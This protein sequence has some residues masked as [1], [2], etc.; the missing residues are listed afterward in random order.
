MLPS[1]LAR[2]IQQG[3]KHFLITGFESADGCDHV[4]MQR[5]VDNE[6]SWMKAPYLQ[7]GL[8]VR[9]DS[10]GRD[11]FHCFQTKHRTYTH[12]CTSWQCLASDRM[13]AHTLVATGTG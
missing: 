10:A 8:P 2:D 5:L 1:L 3:I 9:H 7:V 6:A 12:Q 11:F 13:A 4:V